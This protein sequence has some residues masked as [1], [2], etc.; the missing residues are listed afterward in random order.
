MKSLPRMAVVLALVTAVIALP[1]RADAATA[2]FAKT[3][4]WSAGYVGAF[5]VH[6]DGPATLAG[7]RVEF[8]LPASTQVTSNWSS[9]LVRTGDHYAF[10]NAAWNGVL[11][12]GQSTTFGWV[13][14]GNAAPTGCV[15]NGDPCAG[16]PSDLQAPTAPTGMRVVLNPGVTLVWE[17]ATDDRGVVAYQVYESG[18]LLTTVTG[19]SHV[20]STTNALPP[21]V[22]VFAVRAVDA[23]GNVSPFDFTDLGAA[24]NDQPPVAPTGLRAT[25]G[26]TVVSAAWDR[27]TTNWYP[28][29]PIAGYEVYLDG[30]LAARVGGTSITLRSPVPGRHVLG[31]RA[32]N[33]VDL[34]SPITEIEFTSG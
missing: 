15:L 7:W 16:V 8:D 27:P 11:G 25:A 23:A 18:V 1:S 20:Y 30:V 14:R 10:S 22:Y 9:V 34:Y 17:P 24:W 3:S 33:A 12:P 31:V 32:I 5:T 28:D 19:T 21:K 2:T 6:N 4:D 13:A 26:S 29:T